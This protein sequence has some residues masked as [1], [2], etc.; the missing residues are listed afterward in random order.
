[1]KQTDTVKLKALRNFD[2][3]DGKGLRMKGEVFEIPRILWETQPRQDHFPG[4]VALKDVK[5]PVAEVTDE[6]AGPAEMPPVKGRG[7]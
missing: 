2:P 7:K 4:A 6:P 1:M 3:D 5:P